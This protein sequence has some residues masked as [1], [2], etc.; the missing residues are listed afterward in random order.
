MLVLSG[1]TFF[2]LHQLI[3]RDTTNK[4]RGGQ[5]PHTLILAETAGTGL[6]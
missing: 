2:F 3:T 6:L 1:T 4:P 5:S